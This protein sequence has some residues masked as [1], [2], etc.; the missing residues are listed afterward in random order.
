MLSDLRPFEK[1]RATYCSDPYAM[2]QHQAKF[3]QFVDTELGLNDAEICLQGRSLFNSNGVVRGWFEQLV[4]DQVD[5]VSFWKRYLYWKYRWQLREI[6]IAK[7]TDNSGSKQAERKI[8]DMDHDEVQ[9]GDC[10]NATSVKSSAQPLI[11]GTLETE[12]K[13]GSDD[14]E[15]G[16]TVISEL[17]VSGSQSGSRFSET[18]WT[19]GGMNGHD[20]ESSTTVVDGGKSEKTRSPTIETS[21]HVRDE[22][23]IETDSNDVNV[24]AAS[25]NTEDDTSHDRKDQVDPAVQTDHPVADVVN[26]NQERIESDINENVPDSEPKDDGDESDGSWADWE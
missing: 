23:S 1:E 15:L 19:D 22:Q 16:G 13:H 9:L 7:H 17:R 6:L 25:A 3:S 10:D 11:G 5:E 21:S 20:R 18:A 4:P 26:I 24:E 8:D 14:E 12:R 2:A